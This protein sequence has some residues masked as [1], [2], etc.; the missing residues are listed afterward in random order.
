M[1]GAMWA[2]W[3]E[4]V[5]DAHDAADYDRRRALG[6]RRAESRCD[7]TE[8]ALLCAAQERGCVLAETLERDARMG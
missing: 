7:C 4:R 2:E 8:L 3:L 6:R 5:L 1:E